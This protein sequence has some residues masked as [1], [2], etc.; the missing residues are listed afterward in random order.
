MKSNSKK[1]SHFSDIKTLNVNYQRKLQEKISDILLEKVKVFSLEAGLKDFREDE[2]SLYLLLKLNEK[3]AACFFESRLVKAICL[4][5]LEG[6]LEAKDEDFIS[7]MEKNIFVNL[8]AKEV[9]S[10][11]LRDVFGMSFKNS[12]I[13]AHFSKNPQEEAFE[14][15]NPLCLY[16]SFELSFSDSK[17]VFSFWMPVKHFKEEIEKAD[18]KKIIEEKK[19]AGGK[20][21][22][23]DLID[24]EASIEVYSCLMTIKDVDKL[25]AGDTI[26]FEKERPDS[27]RIRF[28]NGPVLEGTLGMDRGKLAVK[29]N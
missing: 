6:R 28:D 23:P 13:F 7:N 14:G 17:S 9:F 29:I 25:K 19:E 16:S 2:R 26:K 21:I 10:S 12:D 8:F 24:M 4:K 27:V 5:F 22:N 20:R 1:R 3:K 18:V 11:Y 15:G